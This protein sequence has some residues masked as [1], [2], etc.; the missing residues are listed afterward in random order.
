MVLKGFW[1]FSLTCWN[2]Q[3]PCLQ[4]ILDTCKSQGQAIYWYYINMVVWDWIFSQILDIIISCLFYICGSSWF[5]RPYL[6]YLPD[7]SSCPIICIFPT[8]WKSSPKLEMYPT[9]RTQ[10]KCMFTSAAFHN[11]TGSAKGTNSLVLRNC[12]RW[13]WCWECGFKFLISDFFVSS[14]D[15]S[16]EIRAAFK[17]LQYPRYRWLLIR[18]LIVFCLHRLALADHTTCFYL[19]AT[20]TSA[21]SW[22][23]THT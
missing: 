18:N 10:T 9:F 16:R 12:Y 21:A 20:H 22:P 11:L 6:L 2:L 8:W 5:L 13:S 7:C 23:R 17:N 15:L 14:H 3:K 19:P 4:H 1:T